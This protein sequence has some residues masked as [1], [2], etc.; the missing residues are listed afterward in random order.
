MYQACYYDFKT[1]SYHLKDSIEG[2]KNFQY[3]PT[4]YT[5][6]PNGEYTTLEGKR[7]SP[8]KKYDKENTFG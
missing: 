4:Y 8:T 2:W 1:Y 6:N 7:V 3:K 5:E